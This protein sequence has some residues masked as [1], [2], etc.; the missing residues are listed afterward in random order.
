VPRLN[1]NLNFRTGPGTEY[2]LV[3]TLDA[4]LEIQITGYADRTDG[5][6][7]QVTWGGQFGWVKESYTTQLGDCSTIRPAVVPASPTPVPTTPAPPTQAGATSTPTLPDLSLSMLEGARDIQLSTTGT[8]QATYIIRIVNSG[9]QAA[10]QFNV[11][12]LLPNGTIQDLGIV[13]GLTP[14]QEIQIPS[15]GLNVT[16]DSPGIKRL[17]V[18]VDTNNTVA[19]SNESNNQ[20]YLDIT[21]NPNPTPPTATPAPT[22]T[23]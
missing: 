1:V 4:G 22:I 3:K 5:R 18:T 19:E 11:G 10:G 20:A 14:G 21:V 13:A 7:W 8:A 12:V 9:G 17:L 16:F 23:P 15:G 2:D 6:W